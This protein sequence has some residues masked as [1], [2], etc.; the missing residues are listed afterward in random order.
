MIKPIYF[1]LMVKNN[2]TVDLLFD[3]QPLYYVIHFDDH[4][5]GNQNVYGRIATLKKVPLDE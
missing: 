1:P 3:D 2:T 5:T 4:P